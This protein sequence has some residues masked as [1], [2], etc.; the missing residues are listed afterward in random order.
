MV[1]RPRVIDGGSHFLT[2]RV[3]D[4]APTGIHRGYESPARGSGQGAGEEV[5][6]FGLCDWC[7]LHDLLFRTRQN[8]SMIRIHVFFPDRIFPGI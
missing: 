4:A 8:D 1:Q 5:R 7:L 6:Q 2:L 3:D